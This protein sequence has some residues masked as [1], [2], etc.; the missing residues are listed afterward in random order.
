MIGELQAKM[1]GSLDCMEDVFWLCSCWECS[2]WCACQ[3]RTEFHRQW[4]HTA[5][6]RCPEAAVSVF[7]SAVSPLPTWLM[8]SVQGGSTKGTFLPELPCIPGIRGQDP[9]AF[10]ATVSHAKLHSLHAKTQSSQKTHLIFLKTYKTLVVNISWALKCYLC[11]KMFPLYL[12][13]GKTLA[14]PW[15]GGIH[16]FS[17]RA[18][19]S[20]S[21]VLY[22][23]TVGKSA[24]DVLQ[25]L[26]ET[27]V[28]MLWRFF[29]MIQVE[30]KHYKDYSCF[31]DSSFC[32]A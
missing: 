9:P 25:T 27:L 22:H 18:E 17:T 26:A 30:K 29:Y 1:F 14:S 24:K 21:R 28:L 2:K 3:S 8:G 6:A 31:F 7:I 13:A 4:F 32:S 11:T 20:S 23:F 16:L 12:D 19:K 10:L 15:G 5:A